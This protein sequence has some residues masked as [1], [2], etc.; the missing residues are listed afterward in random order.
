MTKSLIVAFDRTVALCYLAALL[1]C[2]RSSTQFYAT[3]GVVSASA[4][5]LQ[6]GTGANG[7]YFYS[8]LQPTKEGPQVK[9]LRFIVDIRGKTLNLRNSFGHICEPWGV[10]RLTDQSFVVRS[11]ADYHHYLRASPSTYELAVSDLRAT[12]AILRGRAGGVTDSLKPI[13]K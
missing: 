13:C 4:F 9:S 10:E 1:A 5:D 12:A 3:S 6:K 2:N 11:G 7:I 8:Y